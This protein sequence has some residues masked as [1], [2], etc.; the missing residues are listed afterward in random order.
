MKISNII[1]DLETV[2]DSLAPQSPQQNQINEIIS[3][4]KD[5]DKSSLDKKIDRTKK[6][7]D[8]ISTAMKIIFDYFLD[9]GP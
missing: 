7:S 6:I 2:R 4:L 1:K 9:T 8:I 5:L 3:K